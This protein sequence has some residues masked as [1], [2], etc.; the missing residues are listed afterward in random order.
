M[1]DS[2][3][4]QVDQLYIGDKAIFATFDCSLLMNSAN[5]QLEKND[6]TVEK[7]EAFQQ[8]WILLPWSKRIKIKTLTDIF[9]ILWCIV[10]EI[11][12]KL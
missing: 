12:N 2:I 9:S 6:F 1:K 7:A 3:N 4:L 11:S 10:P 5:L 8:I